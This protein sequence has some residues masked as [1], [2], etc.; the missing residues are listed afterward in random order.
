MSTARLLGVALLAPFL[1][2]GGLACRSVVDQERRRI[3]GVIESGDGLLPLPILPD[4]VQAGVPFTA[5]VSTFGSPCT[6]PD[7]TDVQTTGLV[8]DLIPYDLL[9]PPETVCEASITAFPRSVT[10]IFTTQGAGLVRLHGSDFK[11]R[12]VTQQRPVTVR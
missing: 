1:L 2:W 4:T 6:R 10:L 12:P 5:T 7:G 9:P 3:V 8:A 11:G